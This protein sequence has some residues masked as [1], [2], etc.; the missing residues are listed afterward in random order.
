MCFCL[1]FLHCTV[2]KR[3]TLAARIIKHGSWVW[4]E[5]LQQ[6]DLWATKHL[7]NVRLIMW[8]CLESSLLCLLE[9]KTKHK[10][11]ILEW[12]VTFFWFQHFSPVVFKTALRHGQSCKRIVCRVTTWPWPVM[13]LGHSLKSKLY[14]WSICRGVNCPAM[15]DDTRNIL[16]SVNDL[17]HHYL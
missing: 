2:S 17:N 8:F 6:A 5:A 9:K 4:D 11:W 15:V 16:F 1:T 14:S 12:S 3:R 7:H 10:F 13:S